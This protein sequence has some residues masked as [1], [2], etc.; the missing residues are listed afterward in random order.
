MESKLSGLGIC[1]EVIP[2]LLHHKVFLVLLS[3]VFL[4]RTKIQFFLAGPPSGEKIDTFWHFHHR[5]VNKACNIFKKQFLLDPHTICRRVFADFIFGD[6]VIEIFL[7]VLHWN[8]RNTPLFA[9][10][11]N[12]HFFGK[13][14]EKCQNR[15]FEW[16][17]VPHPWDPHRIQWSRWS[18]CWI[19]VW[20]DVLVR[21]ILHWNQ[22]NA[23]C[24]LVKTR[25]VG[26]RQ[27]PLFRTLD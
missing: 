14:D 11:V 2:R 12:R 6:H 25:F 18:I 20:K 9:T 3:S 8:H 26:H 4:A 15:Y 13:C 5:I 22:W 27:V 21:Q 24:I 1:Y 17:K 16:N 23:P 10:F 7:H 19:I